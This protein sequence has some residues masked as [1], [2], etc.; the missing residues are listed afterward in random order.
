MCLT[1]PAK[2]LSVSGVSAKLEVSGREK[3]VKMLTPEDLQIGDWVLFTNDFLLKKISAS[4]AEEIFALLKAYPLAE[5][6]QNQELKN[7]LAKAKSDKLQQADI[8][9]LLIPLPPLSEQ[10]R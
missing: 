6:S 10:A 9:Y 4:E 1:L 8:E 5:P 7:I 2:V 3:E